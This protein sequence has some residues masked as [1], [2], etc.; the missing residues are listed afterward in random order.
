MAYRGNSATMAVALCLAA[1]FLPGQALAGDG[2]ADG[3][4][5]WPDEWPSCVWKDIDYLHTGEIKYHVQWYDVHNRCEY[6]IM[7]K[8]DVVDGS[9]R[10]YVLNQWQGY[11]RENLNDVRQIYYCSGTWW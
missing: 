10:E 11:K 6:A 4:R 2:C 3:E 7:I 8:E 5:V 9:D 1:S